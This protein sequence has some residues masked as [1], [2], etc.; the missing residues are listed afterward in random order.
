MI[1]IDETD[2]R[3][4]NS[5]RDEHPEKE[6]SLIRFIDSR[7]MISFNDE[8]PKNELFLNWLNFSLNCNFRQWRTIIKYIIS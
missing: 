8:Q 1:P 3:I 6:P 2:D 7:I 4:L 5:I